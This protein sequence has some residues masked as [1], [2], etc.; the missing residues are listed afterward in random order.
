MHVKFCIKLLF[1]K[2]TNLELNASCEAKTTLPAPCISHAGGDPTRKLEDEMSTRR[3]ALPVAALAL[4]KAL[5]QLQIAR[6]AACVSDE[7]LAVEIAEAEAL[8]ER[9]RARIVGVG[10]G[11]PSAKCER[12]QA[13]R[14]SGAG[15]SVETN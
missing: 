10:K 5:A 11:A 1:V 6:S 15:G 8:L 14:R 13:I 7:N 3:S 2:S 12:A 4:A 9:L